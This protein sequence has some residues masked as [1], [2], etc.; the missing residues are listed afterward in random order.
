[1]KEK[2]GFGHRSLIFIELVSMKSYIT[3][4]LT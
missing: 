4:Q 1:M 3:N 2:V